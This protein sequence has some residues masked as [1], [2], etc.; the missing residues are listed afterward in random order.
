MTNEKPQN[1]EIF[2]KDNI[3]FMVNLRIRQQVLKVLK[4]NFKVR[5]LLVIE[6]KEEVK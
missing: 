3:E 5:E 2:L 6:P 1:D 4:E